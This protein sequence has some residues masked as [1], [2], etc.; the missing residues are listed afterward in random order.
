MEVGVKG[1]NAGGFKIGEDFLWLP[2][3]EPFIMCGH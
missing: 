3:V 1:R 2:V